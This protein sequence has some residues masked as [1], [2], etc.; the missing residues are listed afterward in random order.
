MTSLPVLE[1]TK[2]SQEIFNIIVNN[3]LET[4]T[5]VGSGVI[6]SHPEIGLSSASV[7]AIMAEL[8]GAG[9]LFSPHT[10]SGRLPTHAGLRL[11]VDGL[12]ELRNTL[13][14]DSAP[15][16]EPLAVGDGLSVNQAL[17]KA[18]LALSG[19]SKCAALV[20]APSVDLSVNHIEFVPVQDRKILVILVFSNGHVENRLIEM[21]TGIPPHCLIEASNYMNGHYKGKPLSSIVQLADQDRLQHK[22]ELDLLTSDLIGRGLASWSDEDASDE[23]SLILNGQ[24]NLLKDVR[25]VDDL[26]RVRMLFDKLEMRS[27]ATQ[28]MQSVISADGLQIFIGSEHDLFSETGCSVVLSPYRNA[29]RKIIGAVGVIGPRHMNYARI[30][31]MVDYTSKAIARFLS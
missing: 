20:M 14:V 13:S 24:A 11:F 9:L 29:D 23:A 18:S 12:M 22:A 7:R 10:S 27:H 2:R 15:K 21:P 17:D 4:G 19:L 16:Y 1:I 6:S 26:A 28:L 3:Y 31:P 30:I 8:E 25:V 5:P